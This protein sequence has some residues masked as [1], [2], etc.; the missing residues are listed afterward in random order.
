MGGAAPKP[1][2]FN[3]SSPGLLVSA[4]RAALARAESRPLSRRSG[5]VPAEPYP[6]L[7]CNQCSRKPS[8][9]P[10]T[11]YTELLTPPSL[12]DF[13]R[14]WASARRCLRV[15]VG[16]SDCA[17]FLVRSDSLRVASYV[18]RAPRAHLAQPSIPSG[19]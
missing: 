6:P 16:C 17:F 5:R 7:R 10:K 18:L 13:R 3:A 1:P 19:V 12:T 14:A 9:K 8:T 11:V 15:T 2:G 4:E